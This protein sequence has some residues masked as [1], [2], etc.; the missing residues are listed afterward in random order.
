MLVIP[1]FAA[2][3]ILFIVQQEFVSAG[4]TLLVVNLFPQFI[5]TPPN[6]NNGLV[7]A[8]LQG[9]VVM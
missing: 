4:I 3:V 8:V 7:M 6:S 5:S 9:T 2:Y 1:R